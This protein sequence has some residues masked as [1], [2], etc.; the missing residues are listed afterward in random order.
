MLHTEWNY[1]ARNTI[2]FYVSEMSFIYLLTNNDSANDQNT[3][4]RVI[5]VTFT[6]SQGYIHT[7]KL[8]YL[9]FYKK[10]FGG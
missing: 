10:N 5:K 6:P 7:L 4:R 1:N 9:H 3:M 8:P 2:S